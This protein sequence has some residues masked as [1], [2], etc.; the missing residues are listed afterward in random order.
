MTIIL[1]DVD[2]V[3]IHG[4]HAK[5]ERRR[6]WDE[7][8]ESDF[9]V[10]R[11]D[12]ADT[13]IRGVFA[14]DVLTGR[15]DLY[16]ALKDV[17]PTLGYAGDPQVFIDYWMERDGVVNDDL[18]AHVERLAAVPDLQLF[19]ATN[20][21]NTRAR[22]LMEV[23]G[24]NRYFVDI[25]N[26]GRVGCLKPEPAFFE[27]AEDLIGKPDDDPLIFFDDNQAVVQGAIAA[28]WEAYVFDT[29]D[30]LYQSDTVSDLLRQQ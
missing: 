6:C 14:H 21:E 1:F 8:L 10:S 19:I 26:S 11:E 24:F 12:F 13:F 5:P 25:I 7:E 22:Y 9:G 17:L 4:Y 29:P 2:G 3:L 15:L 23:V 16:A 20:Q 30:D 18:I 27:R 28:G